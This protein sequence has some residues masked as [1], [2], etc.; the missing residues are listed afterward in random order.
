M[1]NT[2]N[3]I[4]DFET[5]N[6][7]LKNASKADVLDIYKEFEFETGHFLSRLKSLKQLN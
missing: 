3:D 4:I 7:L 1:N 2:S 5:Y 6:E